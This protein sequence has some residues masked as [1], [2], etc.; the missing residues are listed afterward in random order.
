MCAVKLIDPSLFPN[1]NRWQCFL[2]GRPLSIASHHFD[3]RMPSYVDPKVDSTGRMFLP[4]LH[5][6]QL[7]YILGGIVDDA[8]SIRPVPYE[9]VKE[10]DRELLAWMDQLPK[11]LDLDEYRL[12]RAL[13]S[14]IPAT[15]RVAVQS[16]VNRSSYFHIRFTLHRPYAAAAHDSQNKAIT[17]G[18]SASAGS[19]R[20]MDER[21]ATSLDTAVNAADKLIQ[22]VGQA[23][24]DLLANS[25]LAVPGHV[26]WGPFHCFSAAMFFSFQLIANPD[27]PGANL[28]RANI[29]RVLD[30]LSMSRGVALADKATDMLA[31]LAPLYEP[32]P[33]GETP[34][35]R[36]NKKK[37][38]LSRVKN[39][40]FPYHDSPA[41]PRSHIDSPVPHA[42]GTVAT[43][44]SAVFN[45]AQLNGHAQ[46][47]HPLNEQL[48]PVTARPSPSHISTVPPYVQH[49]QPPMHNGIAQLSP[50]DS[51]PPPPSIHHQQSQVLSQHQLA[52]VPQP[53]YPPHPQ[54]QRQYTTQPPEYNDATGQFVYSQGS[55]EQSMWGASIGFNQNEWNLFVRRLEGDVPHD[56]LQ[57]TEGGRI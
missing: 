34:A 55:D 27:Q 16:I 48:S 43:P 41:Y 9:R 29:R 46:F 24:P 18:K 32:S 3:T 2:F 50:H 22:L 1:T 19:N 56:A 40:A 42:A 21:M 23:R 4:N 10:R 28:F 15:M 54:S 13:A 49:G 14:P 35:E 53:N 47:H 57:R 51:P 6:F 36:E 44:P 31:A 17:N 8:V 39:L 12:A 26:H 30:I 7:A 25:S 52:G 38:V 45:T 33:P 37:Q 5:L 11:E 20:D